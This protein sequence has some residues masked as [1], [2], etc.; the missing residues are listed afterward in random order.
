MTVTARRILVVEDDPN[1]AE[2]LAFMLEQAGHQVTALADGRAAEAHLRHAPP[3]DLAIFDAMLPYRDGYALTRTA[4]SLDAWRA[5]PILMLT[6]KSLPA[7][8][9]R[10]H[11]VGCTAYLTK[12]FE[13]E[14][15]LAQVQALLKEP[16]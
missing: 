3:A 8:H 13:P 4:R 7:D 11:A 14:D 12:P 5:I 10:G 15:L 1:I 6:A 9:A 2:L 16:G